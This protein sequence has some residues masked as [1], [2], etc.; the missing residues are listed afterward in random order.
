MSGEFDAAL[1]GATDTLHL[2]D[3]RRLA[4][5]IDRWSAAPS[6]ADEQLLRRCTGPVL[7][8]GC[9]PGRLVAALSHRGVVALGVDS[10]P[11]AVRLTAARGGVALCRDVF[12]RLPAEGR[13]QQ[14]LLADGNIGIGGDPV[15]LLRRV[16]R[17]L[18][19]GGLALTEVDQP[20]TGLRRERVRLTGAA[21]DWAWVGADAVGLLA[22]VSGFRV[23]ELVE[24][25]G[26]WFAVLRKEVT[27]A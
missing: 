7:D 10:S 11:V 9:G 5:P 25:G 19:P 26:R 20:G 3:G 15:V 13:W 2:P 17:L 14:V 21:F 8:L 23:R 6:P 22:V 12:G 27:D 4:L 16:H 1:L 24:H 18:A